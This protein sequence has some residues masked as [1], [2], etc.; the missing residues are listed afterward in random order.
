MFFFKIFLLL[1][2]DNLCIVYKSMDEIE[3]LEIQVIGTAKK[4]DTGY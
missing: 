1:Y 2:F 3:R 4:N